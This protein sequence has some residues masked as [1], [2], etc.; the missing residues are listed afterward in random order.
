[1]KNLEN[2]VRRVRT[3]KDGPKLCTH[4]SFLATQLLVYQPQLSQ[5]TQVRPSLEQKNEVI[6]FLIHFIPRDL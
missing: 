1:M 6:V 2:T 5:H 4:L 3:S